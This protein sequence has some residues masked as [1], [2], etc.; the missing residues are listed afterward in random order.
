MSNFDFA[1]QEFIHGLLRGLTEFNISDGGYGSG[2]GN[3]KGGELEVKVGV[4][5]E[6]GMRMVVERGNSLETGTEGGS[7]G[8]LDERTIQI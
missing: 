8:T 2:G 6:V 1:L 3:G 4:G 7:K 5:E